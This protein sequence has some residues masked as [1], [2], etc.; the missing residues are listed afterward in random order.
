MGLEDVLEDATISSNDKLVSRIA[1]MLRHLEPCM[2]S[3][4]CIYR[5]P[6]TLRKLN[7]QAYS[8]HVVS[9]GPFHYG[10]KRL[11]SM[12][13]LKKRYFKR[14]LERSGTRL[15]KYVELVKGFEGRARECY[16]ELLVIGSDE[17]VSMLLI[18]ACFI[19]ELLLR[20]YYT[21]LHKEDGHV[22]STPWLYNRIHSDLILLENQIPFFV[23]EKV[24]VL[25]TVSISVPPIQY[26][27]LCFFKKYN[28]HNA[29]TFR[30]VNHFTDLILI[31]S[32]PKLKR[33]SPKDENFKFKFLYS[34]T[35]LHEAGVKFQ[36]SS[37]ECLLNI[38]FNGDVL[39]MPCFQLGD[40]TETF[41]RNVV[42][43]E[44]CHYP[45]NSYIID[46][47][48]FMDNL[49]NTSKDVDLL[50]KNDIL[51]NWLGD[52]N[53]AANL[54]NNLCINVVFDDDN[55]FFSCICEKLIKYYKI[56]RHEW[57]ATFR[58]DYFSTPWKTASTVAAITLL[59]L[60]LIQT[61]CSILSLII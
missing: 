18:D 57:K 13:A 30:F 41:I 28:I 52:S 8:P 59:V 26:L 27:T 51:V 36:R 58:R 60:T 56:P 38:E 37:N 11:T 25:A 3:K 20:S 40:S 19:I 47:I 5:V 23:L 31:M 48:I 21:D 29:K 9:I 32:R 49:I 45:S 4:C 34:A 35:E 43:L 22:F 55:F 33:L 50:T 6:E 15:R 12:E 54:F 14:L 61:I 1:E 7:E 44:L 53:A 39:K 24:F 16:A 46:Y 42:A 10:S 2:S 17:F